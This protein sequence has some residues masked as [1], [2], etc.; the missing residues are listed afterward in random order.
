MN[1]IPQIDPRLTDI[2]Q[3][4]ES[5][6]PQHSTASSEPLPTAV[7]QANLT[8]TSLSPLY[9]P[10]GYDTSQQ[11]NYSTGTPQLRDFGNINN[12]DGASDPNQYM[13]HTERTPE[14]GINDL[15]RPRACEA[16][17]GLKVKCEF[18]L[19]NQNQDGPCRRCTKARRH[20]VVTQP[21]RKRQKKTDSRVAEL[22]KKIDALTAVLQATRSD[23][24][25]PNVADVSVKNERRPS[26]PYEQVTNGGYGP[27]FGT[28]PDVRHISYSSHLIANSS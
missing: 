23:T 15:K 7:N 3:K 18:D 11:P 22:E 19:N 13:A 24:V 8:P 1:H 9:Q 26:N 25:A 6:Y 10:T 2:G 17:R 5:S 21:S 16:C 28:R 4:S 27:Q 12:N 14:E 20:C